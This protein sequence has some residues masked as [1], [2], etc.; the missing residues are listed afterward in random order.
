MQ[1]PDKVPCAHT[2]L[3]KVVCAK[4]FDLCASLPITRTVYETRVLAPLPRFV[5]G[6]QRWAGSQ[7]QNRSAQPKLIASSV[8]SEAAS[9]LPAPALCAAALCLSVIRMGLS[10]LSA[11]LQRTL[12]VDLLHA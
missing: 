9:L 3:R 1:R 10:W 4:N 2:V 5:R 12:S 6:T 8:T 11:V 7:R